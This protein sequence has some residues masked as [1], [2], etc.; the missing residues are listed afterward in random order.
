[1][2][3][4]NFTLI[5]GVDHT[6]VIRGTDKFGESGSQ[7]VGTRAWDR[8]QDIIAQ[9]DKIEAFDTV[10]GEFYAPLMEKLEA[11][12]DGDEVGEDP[13]NPRKVIQEGVSHVAAEDTLYV[14]LDR[15][16]QL[17][18]AVTLG[19]FDRLSW[20]G[21]QLFIEAKVQPAATVLDELPREDEELSQSPYGGQL[22]TEPATHTEGTNASE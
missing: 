17:I 14:E 4:S 16:G 6:A 22:S 3:N 2:T 1:M 8:Y 19:L 12:E 21:G 15:D 11:L 10:V 18:E 7:L 13:L 9:Q 5:R 20:V